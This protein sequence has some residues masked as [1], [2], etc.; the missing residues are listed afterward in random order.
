MLEK[1][2]STSALRWG[3]DLDQIKADGFN[4]VKTWIDWQSGEP[5]HGV[6]NFENLNLLMR[7]ANERGLRVI[8]QIYLDSAPDWIGRLYPVV[9]L[10]IVAA[11]LL[12][13]SPRLAIASTIPMSKE[14][15]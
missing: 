6:Y 13:R 15:R 12:T 8:V 9:D 1:I 11:R 7:L 10:S 14:K 2:D 5:K 4:T 3:A